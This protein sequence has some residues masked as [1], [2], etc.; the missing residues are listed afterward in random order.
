MTSYVNAAGFAGMMLV[1]AVVLLIW[2]LWDECSGRAQYQAQ[3]SIVISDKLI[4]LGQTDIGAKK[5]LK[6]DAKNILKRSFYSAFRSK[7]SP[8]IETTAELEAEHHRAV[9]VLHQRAKSAREIDPDWDPY[10]ALRRMALDPDSVGWPEK[11]VDGELENLKSAIKNADA[12][13]DADEAVEQIL[14][15]PSN[16][17]Y[18]AWRKVLRKYTDERPSWRSCQGPVRGFLD[19][20]GRGTALGL[21][22]GS[23]MS[24]VQ[25]SWDS[26][27]I[28]ILSIVGGL[29]GGIMY[30]P[31]VLREVRPKSRHQI[32][33]AWWVYVVVVGCA[34]F[35]IKL[36]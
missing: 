34:A 16:P 26:E 6:V 3:A 35:L 8:W 28:A 21:L 30:G 33:V 23:G 18:F 36:F 22:I 19:S 7:N 4:E 5:L 11:I 20:V 27:V 10:D 9:R 25:D 31:S 14:K 1:I 24:L 32:Q 2:L 13:T 12:E 17:G 29:L 15:Q